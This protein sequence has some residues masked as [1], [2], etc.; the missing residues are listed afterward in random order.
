[1]TDKVDYMSVL[2]RQVDDD[3]R[4][5][6]HHH[7]RLPRGIVLSKSQYTLLEDY[8]VAREVEA[9]IRAIAD[10]ARSTAERRTD[11]AAACHTAEQRLTHLRQKGVV[12]F[13][14]NAG[15]LPIQIHPD[16]GRLKL[17]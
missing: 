8:C 12:Y 14:C 7:G 17:V 4:K 16:A 9:F 13:T 10:F 3:V 5:F 2:R 15:N 11:M 1:M 6:I